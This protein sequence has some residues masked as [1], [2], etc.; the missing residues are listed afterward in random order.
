MS[1]FSKLE[2]KLGIKF[3]DPD[4]CKEAFTH[5]S[6]AAEHDLKYD[7]QRLEL[8][9]DAVV[10]IILT[11]E[12]FKRYPS[13]QE[14]ALTKIRS[15][16]VNQDSLARF[17]RDLGLGDNLRLGRGEK[18]MNGNDRASTL[19][20]LFEAL[21]GAIYLD[22]GL[23]TA[24]K[25]FLDTLDRLVPDPAAV[26]NDLNPKGSL[27]EFTQHLGKGVPQYKVLSV[28]GPDHKPVYEVEV[29]LHGIAP[30]TASATN[31]KQAE[32]LAAG[33]LLARLKKELNGKEEGKT[34]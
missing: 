33:K 30:E 13:L 21:T 12:L 20:D 10:Q 4:L 9:G 18:E 14:G 28:S 31:R 22:Q 24:R 6:F 25:F 2:E 11:E 27:Q 8:L 5:K 23:K 16:L 34:E 17:A 19:C 3:K 32:G 1:E 7:N 29:S 15:A 26:L